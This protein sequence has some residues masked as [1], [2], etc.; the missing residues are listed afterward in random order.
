MDKCYGVYRN[1]KD[2][3]EGLEKIR[4]LK[5]RF[6]DIYIQDSG[7][8]YNNNMINALETENLLYLAEGLA[9]AALTREE[10]RGGHARTDFPVRDDEKW[11]KHT[12]I[13]YTEDGP[14]LSYKPVTITKWLPV[15]RKY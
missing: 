9:T 13:T 1:G 3:S 11:L 2:L 4:E 8:V 12:L 14:K 5:K 10:S 15:E 6:A 7:H